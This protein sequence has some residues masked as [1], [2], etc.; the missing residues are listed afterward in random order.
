MCR[1]GDIIVIK[2]YESHGKKL[3]RHSFVVLGIGNG[4]IE[5]MDFDMVC[6]VMSSFHSDEHRESKL[7]FHGNI[8]YA[9]SDE[10]V[11]GGHGI[12]GYIKADQL[13]YFKRDL[14]EYYVIG[15]VSPELFIRLKEFINRLDSIERITDNLEPCR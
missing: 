10:N 11:P 9:P 6:N 12:G 13:Y 5:G 3:D 8:E 1:V 4:E 14:I 15:S 2:N 7:R